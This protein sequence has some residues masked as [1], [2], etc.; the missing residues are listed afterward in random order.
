MMSYCRQTIPA[1]FVV[2]AGSGRP[3]VTDA[4]LVKSSALVMLV[5]RGASSVSGA[6]DGTLTRQFENGGMVACLD[7]SKDYESGAIRA[8]GKDV[9]V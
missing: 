2:Q 8:K 6:I 7:H 5:G 9:L 4:P 3:S 1:S